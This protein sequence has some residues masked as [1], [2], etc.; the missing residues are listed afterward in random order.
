[1]TIALGI[2]TPQSFVVG[3]DSQE[4]SGYPGDFKTSVGKIG[5]HATG[6]Q[7]K[8]GLRVRSVCVAGAGDAGYLGVIKQEIIERFVEMGN[9]TTLSDFHAELKSIVQRFYR[10]HIIPFGNTPG[11]DLRVQLIVGARSFND[12]RMWITNLTTVT[13]KKS[14]AGSDYYVAIGS[15]ERWAKNA[16]AGSF[17]NADEQRSAMLAAYAVFVAKN[18]AEGCGGDTS[19]VSIRE[20]GPVAANPD[21]ILELEKIFRL[22]QKTEND[23][24][25][26]VFGIPRLDE[27]KWLN[28]QNVGK[29]LAAVASKL[30]MIDLFNPRVSPWAAP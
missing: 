15:G 7:A 8:D 25:R 6:Y 9:R 4:G 16:V 13:E 1:M 2:L 21:S 5:W 26:S 23:A 19:I 18:N 29:R 17:H 3:A 22:Y 27:G 14:A 24:K 10:E 30:S 12:H 20:D 28:P 11:L